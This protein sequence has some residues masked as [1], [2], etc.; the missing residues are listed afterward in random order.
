MII[1]MTP[2]TI[3]DL[4]LLSCILILGL[5][6]RLAGMETNSLTFDEQWHLEL[7]TGRGSPHVRL[8]QDV[9]IA[10]A[11]AVTS[12]NGAPPWYAVWTH[13]DFVVHPPLYCTMLRLWRD[14]F[15][16][17]DVAARSLSIVC[18][19]IAIA[20]L[21]FIVRMQFGIWPAACA[22][23]LMAVAPTQI[24]L[25]HQVREYMLLQM[26]GMAALFAL[27][28]MEKSNRH[29]A[30]IVLGICVLAMMLTHYFAIGAAIA[31]GVYVL[32][33]FRGKTR[34]D[35]IVALLI[36]GIFYTIV[37]GPFAW[38]QRINVAA[39]ADVW[40]MEHSP[41]H[42]LMTLQRSASWLWRLAINTDTNAWASLLAV[43]GLIAVNILLRRKNL[44]IWWLWLAGTLGFIATLD[45]AR[46]TALLNFARYVSLAS[47]AIFVLLVMTIGTL[48]AFWRNA[49]PIAVVL[50]SLICWR[51]ADVAEEPDWREL[52]SVIDQ[53]VA[54]NE[55]LIF[56]HGLQPDWYDQIFYLGSAHYSHAFPHTILKLSGP[57]SRELV[58]QIPGDS[59][60]L[61]SG[62]LG[63]N[64]SELLPGATVRDVYVI[65]NLAVC[66]HVQL[67]PR[68]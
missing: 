8:P 18:S 13:M 16:D 35:A 24:F 10:N 53:H 41:M 1:A 47:P 40:L 44:L 63:E 62:Q 66:T 52:G 14:A 51:M 29:G 34:R 22:A 60:W 21:F 57:A 23:L 37:W 27:L 38:Q 28:R 61:I 5:G 49:V 19:L 33:R 30:A 45:S 67:N 42:W 48:P 4:I 43:I 65:P 56:F 55:T 59:A 25:A 46:G 68:N 54:T 12:L 6:L 2:H 9:V 64:V 7:S 26:L 50:M 3:R 32:I 36:A 17:G 58:R 15:G 11:P 39:T 31:I 20:L